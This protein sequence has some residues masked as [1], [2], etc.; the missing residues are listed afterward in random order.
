MKPGVN[1]PLLDAFPYAHLTY[2]FVYMKNRHANSPIVKY[3][4]DIKADVSY[5]QL[6]FLLFLYSPCRTAH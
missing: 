1:D 5:Q 2:I 6:H 4:N 3:K